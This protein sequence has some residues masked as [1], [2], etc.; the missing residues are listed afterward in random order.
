MAFT[1][2]VEGK[3]PKGEDAALEYTWKK[4]QEKPMPDA[5]PF[6]LQAT[7]NELEFIRNNFNNIPITVGAGVNKCEWKGEMAQFIF[8]NL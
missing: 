5:E 3:D 7:G 8:D 2:L 6:Y 4:G 1:I